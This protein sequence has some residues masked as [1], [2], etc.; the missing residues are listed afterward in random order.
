L[1]EKNRSVANQQTCNPVITEEPNVEVKKLTWNQVMFTQ[2][3]V[4]IKTLKLYV[5]V[6][7]SV[8]WILLFH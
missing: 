5:V 7:L 2:L 3:V 1:T 4:L 8:V 6:Y